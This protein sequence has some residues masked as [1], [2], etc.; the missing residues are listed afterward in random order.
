MPFV[1][2]YVTVGTYWIFYLYRTWDTPPEVV[3]FTHLPPASFTRRTG[4]G[5]TSISEYREFAN[6]FTTF[7][8]R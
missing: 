6:K 3:K 1:C 4:D 2:L 8:E 7:D 5:N